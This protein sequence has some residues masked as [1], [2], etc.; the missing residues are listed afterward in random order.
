MRQDATIL[1]KD[2]RV[3]DYVE[4]IGRVKGVNVRR[5]AL[6]DFRPT[7]FAGSQDSVCPRRI[8]ATYPH[9][10]IPSGAAAISVGRAL[11]FWRCSR[12]SRLQ[13][14]SSPHRDRAPTHRSNG[15]TTPIPPPFF[16]LRTAVE[17]L[18]AGLKTW[19]RYRTAAGSGTGEHQLVSEQRTARAAPL[20]S[21]DPWHGATTRRSILSPHNL[22]VGPGLPS[23]S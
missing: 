21:A 11:H 12:P 9:P 10:C 8:N 22:W 5:L 7:E 4:C 3:E 18:A 2:A 6:L 23:S 13:A 14:C 20:G 1:P 17:R 19:R 15:W 16:P